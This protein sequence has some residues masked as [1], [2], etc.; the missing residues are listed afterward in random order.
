MKA[1]RV[2]E[3]SGSTTLSYDEIPIPVLQENEVLVDIEIAGV[4]FIDTSTHN[5]LYALRQEC[6]PR[7]SE[8]SAPDTPHARDAL[9][10][11]GSDTN[12]A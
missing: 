4:N 8:H 1:T 6:T 9:R 3:Y 7:T 5:G 2:A 10:D 11:P 12:Q